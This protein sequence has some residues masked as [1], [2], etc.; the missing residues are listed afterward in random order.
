MKSFWKWLLIFLGV[1][2]VAFL[3]A[4]PFFTRLGRMAW[5]GPMIMMGGIRRGYGFGF[6]GGWLMMLGMALGWVLIAALIIAGIVALVRDSS[7]QNATTK[8]EAAAATSTAE[9]GV[10]AVPAMSSAETTP[11][12]E[13]CKRCGK[14][15]QPDWVSCPYCGKKVSHK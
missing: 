4:L 9:P 10:A 11:A 6:G 8:S 3:I 14:P 7:H 5:W 1:L 15:L 12:T 13:T 2:V